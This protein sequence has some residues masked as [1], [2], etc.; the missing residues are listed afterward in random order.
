VF[1]VTLAGC[2]TSAVCLPCKSWMG[3]VPVS[4]CSGG[5]YGEVGNTLGS[6]LRS[7]RFVRPW[8]KIPKSVRKKPTTI[9]RTGTMK[10]NARS[11]SIAV[12]IKAKAARGRPPSIRRTPIRAPLS[13]TALRLSNLSSSRAMSAPPPAI[14]SRKPA[15]GKP[16]LEQK[17]ISSEICCWLHCGQYMRNPQKSVC[18]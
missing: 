7:F 18:S 12:R 1:S 8:Q 9:S 4:N 10:K 3:V 6:A 17:R 15:S 11:S 16:H 2:R 14:N 13:A 5:R